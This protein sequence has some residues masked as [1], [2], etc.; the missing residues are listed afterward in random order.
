MTLP[1]TEVRGDHAVAETIHAAAAAQ[2]PLRIA[3]RGTWLDGGSPVQSVRTLSLAHDTGVTHYT[4]GDF[5]ITVRAGTTLSELDETLRAH[6]Q[7]LPL[8]PQGGRDVTIGATV[9]TCSYGPLAELY[10][11]A[12]DQ[13]LGMTVVTGKGEIIH[14]GGRVVKNVAGF[15]LTRL[16]IGAWGTLGVITQVTLRVR[17]QSDSADS[18]EHMRHPMPEQYGYRVP[19]VTV[20]ALS[21][22]LKQTFDPHHILNPNIMGV[23]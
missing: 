7:W 5:V 23:V 1:V 2:A 3:G 21:H 22:S 6:R 9:A 15:D 4:P 10:G 16:M 11:T 19:T 12:R 8:D 18:L 20:P 14:P 13:V 17:A